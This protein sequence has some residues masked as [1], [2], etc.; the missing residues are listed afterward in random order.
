MIVQGT[1]EPPDLAVIADTGREQS[2]TW[3]YMERVT[4]PALAAIGVAMH[5][6]S[7]LLTDVADTVAVARQPLAHL[8][9]LSALHRHAVS[10]TL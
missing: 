5:A 4:A 2:T 1:I 7:R 6:A 8:S 10:A 9:R 3:A